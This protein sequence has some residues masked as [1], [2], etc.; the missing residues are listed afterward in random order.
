MPPFDTTLTSESISE[1]IRPTTHHLQV[2]PLLEEEEDAANNVRYFPN[3]YVVTPVGGADA[4][5]LFDPLGA[6]L[7][8]WSDAPENASRTAIKVR[9][10]RLPSAAAQI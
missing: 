8:T 5:G 6:A 7:G 3:S 9:K 10:L 1:S 4:A 2:N